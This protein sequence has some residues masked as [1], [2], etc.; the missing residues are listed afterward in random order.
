MK[1]LS[2]NTLRNSLILLFICQSIYSLACDTCVMYEYNT[3]R[4][5]S[6]VGLFYRYRVFNGFTTENQKSNFSPKNL[7]LTHA[8]LGDDDNTYVNSY[9]SYE[10]FETY[11]LRYNHNFKDKY[12]VMLIVPFVRNENYFGEIIPLIGSAF[13]SLHVT[14]GIGDIIISAERLIRIKKEKTIHNIKIGF[15]VSLPTGKF[16]LTNEKGFI[17]DPSHQLG[18]GAMNFLPR[19]K[20]QAI[21]DQRLGL[22]SSLGYAFSLKRNSGKIANGIQSTYRFGNR[23]N[24]NTNLFFITGKYTDFKWI[25]KLGLYYE[26]VVNDK[27][28]EILQENTGGNVAFFNIGSDFAYK[29]FHIQ[30]MYQLP[31]FENLNGEQLQ[32]AGRIV[33]GLIY[34]F[35][36]NDSN[37]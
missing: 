12:N 18:N 25:P 5:N 32:N 7:R 22:N 34:N 4:N 19:L 1:N 11:E 6:Y 3:I 35:S 13:D 33:L 16:E 20:Y 27:L 14:Q 21:I 10:I 23:L 17:T 2:Q 30:T 29:D 28:N 37:E 9:K 15:A 26:N 8:P 24:V 36:Y 31:I